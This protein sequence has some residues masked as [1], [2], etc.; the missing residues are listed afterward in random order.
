MKVSNQV[1]IDNLVSEKR[2][3]IALNWN[4]TNDMRFDSEYLVN[5]I[6]KRLEFIKGRTMSYDTGLQ[7]LL[8]PSRVNAIFELAGHSYTVSAANAF[9]K[10]YRPTEHEICSEYSIHRLPLPIELKREIRKNM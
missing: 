8:R 9:Y 1:S 4:Q 6:F 3:I 5:G 2:Y 10:I 7:I